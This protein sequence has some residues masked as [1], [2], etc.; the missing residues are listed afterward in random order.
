MVT[1]T[2]ANPRVI[3]DM[4]RKASDRRVPVKPDTEQSWI[5][6]EP[7]CISVIRPEPES[8]TASDSASSKSDDAS[9]Y[10]HMY[11]AC[12]SDELEAA[13]NGTK[14]VGSCL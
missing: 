4:K 6:L 2:A 8:D 3:L 11:D 14:I 10:D 12:D 13:L 1:V 9:D 7:E 5:L